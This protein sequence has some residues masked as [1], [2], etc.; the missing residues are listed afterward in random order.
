MGDIQ[1]QPFQLSFKASL[2]IDFRDHAS[3][4][5]VASFWYASWTNVWASQTH[6]PAPDRL[7]AR[8]EQAASAGGPVAPV[9]LQSDGGL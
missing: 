5:M 7:T 1:N 3:P 2:K 8:E 6:R 9:R 4:P